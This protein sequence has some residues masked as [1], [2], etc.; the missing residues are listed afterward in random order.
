[1][2]C[3]C[4]YAYLPKGAYHFQLEINCILL[5]CCTEFNCRGS[6]A[7]GWRHYMETLPA[8]LAR[9]EG[10]S[11]FASGFPAQ[12]ESGTAIWYFLWCQS[13]QTAM[14]HS[15]SRWIDM[16]WCSFDVTVMRNSDTCV[17]WIPVP[18]LKSIWQCFWRQ[19]KWMEIKR[20]TLNG[21]TYGRKDKAI[22]IPRNCVR[23]GHQMCHGKKAEGIKRRHKVPDWS[24]CPVWFLLRM[25]KSLLT[26][27]LWAKKRIHS[28][29]QMIT[30]TNAMLTVIGFYIAIEPSVTMFCEI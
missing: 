18:N 29:R 1:M 23:R 26:K 4:V 25:R 6:N 16:V 19:L 7:T 9:C 20:V 11:L 5:S 10:N 14:K 27:M 30:P 17:K 8:L 15:R 12:G 22:L 13:G 24:L 28:M 3:V 2:V 21:W